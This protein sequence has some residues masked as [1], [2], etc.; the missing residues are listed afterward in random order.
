MILLIHSQICF[1]R[2]F[3][4]FENCY[5]FLWGQKEVLLTILT[6]LQQTFNLL[7]LDLLHIPTNCYLTWKRVAN[8]CFVHG[9]S[10]TF[11]HIALVESFYS[12]WWSNDISCSTYIASIY[13]LCHN[14]FILPTQI[15][16]IYIEQPHF[17]TSISK[18][19][20]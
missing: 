5:W 19:N 15:M 14:F 3:D 7:K 6:T 9:W 17:A 18:F 2:L 16:K 20:F 12:Y 1:C 10:K 8:F 11:V 13:F 4:A